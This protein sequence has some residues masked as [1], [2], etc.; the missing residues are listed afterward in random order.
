MTSDRHCNAETLD[1]A[2]WDQTRALAHQMVDDAIDQLRNVRD[3]PIW[4][5]MPDP[6]RAAFATPL[7]LGPQPLIEVYSQISDQVMPYRMGMA[8][9]SGPSRMFR[10]WSMASSTI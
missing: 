9:Q 4:Q 3:R 7:P 8:C 5:A 10:S 2:N 1:P 6:V